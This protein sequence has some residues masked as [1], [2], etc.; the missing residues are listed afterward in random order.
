MQS[1]CLRYCPLGRNFKNLIKLQENCNE[2]LQRKLSEV[3]VALEDEYEI[4]F[5]LIVT[6]GLTSAAQHDLAVF[7]ETIAKPDD[8]ICSINLIDQEELKRRY[9]MALEKDNPALRHSIQ[10]EPGKYIRM[11]IAG[12]EAI[13]AAYPIE[14][15]HHFPWN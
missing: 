6:A 9:D 3:S 13:M 10:L 8:L 1:L 4:I 12:T 7:Q 2:M 5:K 14:R 15:L 11:E